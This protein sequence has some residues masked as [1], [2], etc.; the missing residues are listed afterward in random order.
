MTNLIDELNALHVSLDRIAAEML[1]ASKSLRRAV[2]AIQGGPIPLLHE[3][4]PDLET[5]ARK[6]NDIINR[7]NGR[8]EDP[9]RK[10]STYFTRLQGE[11][12]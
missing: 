2:K 4:R 12:R 6:V 9:D 5:I 11:E 3:T 10:T 1:D 7:L 8:R